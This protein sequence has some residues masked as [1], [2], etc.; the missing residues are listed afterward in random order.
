MDKRHMDPLEQC[1][2]SQVSS[3]NLLD[4][5]QVDRLSAN[6]AFQ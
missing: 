5:A 1:K 4:K 6:L 3:W 2:Y